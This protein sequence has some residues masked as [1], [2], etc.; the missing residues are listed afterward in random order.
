[1]MNT[2][3]TSLLEQGMNSVW[4]MVGMLVQLLIIAFAVV[5]Y[6]LRSVGMDG[7]AAATEPFPAG[8]HL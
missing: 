1:M 4:A 5:S 6:V 8:R 3:L 2:E 7:V